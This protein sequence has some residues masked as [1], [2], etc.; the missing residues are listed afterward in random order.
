M[1]DSFNIVLNNV[2][3]AMRGLKVK[4]KHEGLIGAASSDGFEQIKSPSRDASFLR[5]EIF[6][7]T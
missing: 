3:V 5:N 6:F 2:A 1:I 4:P 7:T